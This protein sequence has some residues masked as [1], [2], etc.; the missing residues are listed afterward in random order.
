MS[1][2]TWTVADIL[3]VSADFLAKKDPSSP[4]LEAELLLSQVL[5]LNRVSLYVNF[6][7]VLSPAE[8]GQYR[9]LIRRRGQHE[10][11]AYILGEKEFYNLKLAVTKDTLIP[12][13]ETEHLVDEALR[14]LKGNMAPDGEDRPEKPQAADVGCGSG[15]IGLAL[16]SAHKGVRVSATD[17]SAQA[18][19]VARG[20]AE[21][22]KL[23][24]RME[25]FEGD[26]AAP[27]AGR[28]FDLICANLPYIP[29]AEMTTLP[30]DVANFEPSSAL[31]GGPEGTDLIERL[32]P[33]AKELL[34]PGGHVL[35][36]IWPR[37]LERVTALALDGGFTPLEP[38]VDYAQH[39]RIFVAQKPA[40]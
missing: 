5:K 16:V 12:R 28:S 9:E 40:A 23:G 24:A 1:E 37:S 14:L 4:R 7:R 13:P 35:L 8:V 34:K 33:Q 27:L 32:L 21:R 22:L 26:L 11:V 38:V 20:N 3:A 36:E 30:P 10:P 25:F 39:D 6:E 29:D 19:A 18:L 31:K 15:A 17:I 2:K